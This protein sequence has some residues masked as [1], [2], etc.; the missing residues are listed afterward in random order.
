MSELAALHVALD[1]DGVQT[2]LCVVF[3]LYQLEQESYLALILQER[4]AEVIPNDCSFARLQLCVHVLLDRL[5]LLVLHEW[6]EGP[7]HAGLVLYGELERDILALD[8]VHA[9][10]IT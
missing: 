9:H 5:I 1:N 8:Y 10:I 2:E 7:G 6:L 3:G 4:S